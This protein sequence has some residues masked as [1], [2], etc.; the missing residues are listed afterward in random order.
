MFVP[1]SCACFLL[2]CVYCFCFLIP[3]YFRLV[4]KNTCN[5]LS[6]YSWTIL[7]AILSPPIILTQCVCY[8][9][10]SLFFFKTVAFLRLF[11]WF[12]T[13][14]DLW[15]ILYGA[16]AI[17]KQKAFSSAGEC[18]FVGVKSVIGVYAIIIW[19]L[20][21][22]QLYAKILYLNTSIYVRYVQHRHSVSMVPNSDSVLDLT[23]L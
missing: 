11:L 7:A 17:W 8:R 18:V 16:D 14:L 1:K 3:Y 22:I 10:K 20:L 2:L 21:I 6:I 19:S 5:N 9:K 13:T 23:Y 12:T 4:D 15:L